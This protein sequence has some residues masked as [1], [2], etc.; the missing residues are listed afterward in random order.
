[1]LACTAFHRARMFP[2]PKPL[3]PRRSMS[4]RKN[5]SSSNTC[6]VNNWSRY[7][8]QE[9]A[10]HQRSTNYTHTGHAVPFVVISSATLNI[11]NSTVCLGLRYCRCI[12]HLFS[13]VWSRASWRMSVSRRIPCWASLSGRWPAASI[14]CRLT[15][16]RVQAGC[17]GPGRVSDRMTM[18]ETL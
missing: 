8:W 6:L 10:G 17:E 9:E 16:A 11:E 3:A 18:C 14:S 5:V 4:S 7:L 12:A 13:A 15:C 2:S 1:M